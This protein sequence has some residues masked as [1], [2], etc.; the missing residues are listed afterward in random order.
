MSTNLTAHYAKTLS[1]M[2]SF[3][4]DKVAICIIPYMVLY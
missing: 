4:E 2:F 3:V 1:I